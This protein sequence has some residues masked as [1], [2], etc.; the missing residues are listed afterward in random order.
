MPPNCS[1]GRLDHALEV[2]GVGGVGDQA[3]HPGTARGTRLHF[4]S[5]GVDVR[6]CAREHDHVGA[7]GRQTSRHRFAQPLARRRD[8][9]A[10]F[11]AARDPCRENTKKKA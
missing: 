1:S 8:N 5:R 2:G 7:L 11:P 10:S 4:G 3:D 9:R 6:L